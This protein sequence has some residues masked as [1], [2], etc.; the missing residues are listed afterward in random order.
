MAV[1]T[2]GSAGGAGGT[3]NPNALA[4]PVVVTTYYNNQGWFGDST[5][6]SFF[7]TGSTLISQGASTAGP[8]A[9]RSPGALGQ[10]L[11]IVYTPPPGL[12]PADGGAGTY[13]GVFFLTTLMMSHPE[14]TPPAAIGS[15]NWGAEPGKLLAPGATKI[16]FSAASD[17]AGLSVAFKAGASTDPFTLPDQ[18]ESLTTSWQ[19]YS[20]SL[21]GVTYASPI[22][23]AFAWVITDTSRPATFWWRAPRMGTTTSAIS[24]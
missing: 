11:K 18:V 19:S 15:A 22:L 14:L 10:C 1:G 6:E 24:I 16:A 2:T 8:C 12:A 3:V 4:L 21:D 17:T 20:L 9:A 5:I 7:T 23:G 13:L